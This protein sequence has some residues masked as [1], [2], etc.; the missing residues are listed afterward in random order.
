MDSRAGHADIAVFDQ[1]II[2][3]KFLKEG[4][5]E[6]VN[7]NKTGFHCTYVITLNVTHMGLLRL[8]AEL[9]PLSMLYL[10]V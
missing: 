8:L 3:G 7:S 5:V 6:S 2:S 10:Q 9:A 4:V 1:W